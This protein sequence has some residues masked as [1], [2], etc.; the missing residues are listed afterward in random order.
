MKKLS[1]IALVVTS[2]LGFSM[3][4]QAVDSA[5]QPSQD[6]VVQHLKLSPE[7][8]TKINSLHSQMTENLGKISFQE[9]KK[10]ALVDAVRADKWDEKAINEQLTAVSKVE[11]QVRYYRVKYYFD[12]N[13]VLTAEQREIIRNDLI[14]AISE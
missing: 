3:S 1:L 9:V 12:L 14:Q 10:G 6:P 2:F 7:Q 5:P 13:Q 8:V 4:A 11:T